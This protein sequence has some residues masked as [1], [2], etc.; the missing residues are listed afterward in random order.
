MYSLRRN[1]YGVYHG[2]IYELAH[3][4]FEEAALDLTGL[5][6]TDILW[7]VSNGNPVWFVSNST[8]APLGEDSFEIWHTPTGIVK[9]TKRMHAAVITGYDEK[10]VYIND[11]LRTPANLKRDRENFKDAWEQ[12]GSQAVVI[13]R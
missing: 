10:Y 8:Y 5:D 9:I 4:Y 3:D 13:F 1:G 7:F 12:M 11:P 6:F 2:P